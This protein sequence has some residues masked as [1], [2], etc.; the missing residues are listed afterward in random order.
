[1][2]I[3]HSDI[4]NELHFQGL[5]PEEIKFIRNLAKL[6]ASCIIKKA[7]EEIHSVRVCEDIRRRSK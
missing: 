1:M 6:T 3:V 2:D 4:S 5:T 7:N